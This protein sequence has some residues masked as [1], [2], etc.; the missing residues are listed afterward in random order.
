MTGDDAAPARPGEFTG[1]WDAIRD[2]AGWSTLARPLYKLWFRSEVRG[3]DEFPDGGALVVSNHS[4]GVNPPDVPIFWIDFFAQ[5]RLRPPDLHARPR[6]HLP[7]TGQR[8]VGAARHDPRHPRQCGEGIAFGR[9]GDRLPGRGLR[10]AAAD[11]ETEHHRL[12]RPDRLCRDRDRGRSADSPRGVDRRRRRPSC[13]C[14]AASGWGNGS[15]S[16]DCCGPTRLLW[17]SA[18]RSV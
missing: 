18:S 2:A 13:S 16:N 7:R 14:P 8:A 15:G 1:D 3:L 9:V 12:R 4:G 5:V 6:H 11:V 10:L 17:P